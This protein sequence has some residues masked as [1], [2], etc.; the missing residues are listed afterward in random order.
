MEFISLF[1]IIGPN[2]IGPSSSHTA[3]ACSIAYLAQS[4]FKGEIKKVEFTLYG[5][6]AKTYKGHGTDK[7]LVAGILG[8]KPDDKHIRTS[9]EEASS[10]GIE[11][12]FFTNT[13][14]KPDHP[15]TVDI[16]IVSKDDKHFFIKGESIGG[17]KVQITNID[18]IDVLFTGEYKTLIIKQY[19]KQGVLFKIS[20]ILSKYKV[21]IATVKLYR[22]EKNKEAFTILENDDSVPAEAI[23]ELEAL[24]EVTEVIF[25]G[26]E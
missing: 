9:F 15:N 8:Y 14:D 5:S 22:K 4:L 7:A 1:D 11:Y 13:I 21:N 10:R 17:G 3:G 6:F 24:E 2:M 25:L 19:D 18:G 16:L 12:S 26:K 23:K 20:S